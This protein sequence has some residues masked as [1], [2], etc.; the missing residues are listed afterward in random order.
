MKMK[1]ILLYAFSLVSMNIMAQP[2]I[3]DIVI[4]N[5]EDAHD[6]LETVEECADWILTSS[7][8]PNDP[9][10]DQMSGF[11]LNWARHTNEFPIRM[12]TE[13]TG[14]MKKNPVLMSVYL[15]G[16]I[17]FAIHHP[18]ARGNE[19]NCTDAA[20]T[21]CVQF[22]ST[23]KEQ[24]KTDPTLDQLVDVSDQG[25]LILWISKELRELDSRSR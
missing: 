13:L 10:W 22:Y 9:T 23:H 21:S 15:A 5:A 24:L 25:E 18:E 2:D 4:R 16:W 7:Y 19:L 8:N 6:E 14:F 12:R 3:E 1:S 17:R 20:L 11:I